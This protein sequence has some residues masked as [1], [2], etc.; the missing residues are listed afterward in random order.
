MSLCS[1]CG[2]HGVATVG[3]GRNRVRVACSCLVPRLH[4]EM[5]ALSAELAALREATASKAAGQ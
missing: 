2:G 3:D 1:I 4:R 5:A